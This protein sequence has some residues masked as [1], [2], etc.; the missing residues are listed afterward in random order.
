M[1]ERIPTGA[2]QIRSKSQSNALRS[3]LFEKR[4]KLIRCNKAYSA[5][6][7]LPDESR[8]VEWGRY[9][10]YKA[11]TIISHAHGQELVR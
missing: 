3:K 2:R 11:V 7:A 1:S 8:I 9:K 6:Q 10:Q 5:T 4:G